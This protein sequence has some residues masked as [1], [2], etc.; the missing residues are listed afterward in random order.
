[1]YLW[2][3][4]SRSGDSSE[5]VAVLDL[6]L[7]RHPEI[8]HLVVSCNQ[9]GQMIQR[10]VSHPNV[11]S[12]VLDDAVNDRSL[13]MTSSFSN[14]VVLGHCLAHVANPE[15][16]DAILENLIFTG[17]AFLNRADD[18]AAEI[19]GQDYSRICFL[20][21][22]TLNAVAQE[23]A[24]KVLELTAGR[25]FTMSESSLGLRHGPLSALDDETLMVSFLSSEARR[26]SY[27]LDLLKEVKSKRLT[28]H[29]LA[30]SPLLDSSL[31]GLVDSVLPLGGSSPVLDAYRPPV[32]VIFAQLLGMFSSLKE[33]LTPDRPSRNGAIHRVVSNLTIY[34]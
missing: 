33:G 22:G 4:F 3:S 17:K 12:I 15:E 18:T 24:L 2:I 21:S 26:R 11:L 29:V 14:M 6:A 25:I 5:G 7:E 34:S 28:K 8:R 10:F 23:A 16:Y 9:H 19:A 13:A 20:G 27:E 31:H 32:D 30:I 1:L